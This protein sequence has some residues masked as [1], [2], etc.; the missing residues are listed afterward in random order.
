MNGYAKILN[1]LELEGYC[2]WTV[3]DN[4]G[5]IVVRTNNIII[6]KQL[7]NYIWQQNVGKATRT[8]YYFDILSVRSTDSVFIDKVL[9]EYN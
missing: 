7:M 2:D 8:I 1:T 9:I 6:I 3:F 5:E 4:F